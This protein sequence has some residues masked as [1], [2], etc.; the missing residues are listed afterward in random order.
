MS[1]EVEAS[2]VR[3]PSPGSCLRSPAIVV[4]GPVPPVRDGRWALTRRLEE[5]RSGARVDVDPPDV[6]QLSRSGQAAGGGSLTPKAALTAVEFRYS[7]MITGI[8][9]MANA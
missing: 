3:G 5:T 9:A 1:A 4:S 6:V 8:T 7:R 2:S